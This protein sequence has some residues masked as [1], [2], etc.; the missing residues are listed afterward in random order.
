MIKEKSNIQKFDENLWFT[1]EEKNNL[2]INYRINDITFDEYSPYQHIM[3]ADTPDF[4]SMLILDGIVQSTSADGFIYN[5]MIAHIPICSHPNP[6]NILIIGGGDCGVAREITKYPYVEKID[7]VEIDE[8]VVK[9]CK[10]HL[11]EVSGN[12]NDN[13]VNF[14]YAD[15]IKFVKECRDKYDIVIVDSSDPVG[16]AVELFS[17]DFYRN[18][19]NILRDDGIFACQSESPI[20]YADIMKDIYIKLYSI[21]SE[22]K[23]YTAVVPTYPGGLWS[24]TMASKKSIATKPERLCGDTQ[25]INAGILKSCFYLP[26]FVKKALGI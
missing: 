6:K 11:K 15:G 12:L 14:I 13:R 21:Y 4:G 3:I 5:E 22:V 25:Y 9:A 17:M 16:P 18:I 10:E 26:E 1:E 8:I 2:R 23:V 19:S 20:F 7:M 24:F